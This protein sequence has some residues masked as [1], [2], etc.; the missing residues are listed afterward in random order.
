MSFE[1][2][3]PEIAGLVGLYKNSQIAYQDAKDGITRLL[4]N[5]LE[6]KDVTYSELEKKAKELLLEKENK[7]ET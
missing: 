1:L 6:Y 2:E 4:F 5:D 7:N 3:N